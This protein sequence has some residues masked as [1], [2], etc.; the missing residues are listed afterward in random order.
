MTDDPSSEPAVRA[1]RQAHAL[2]NELPS[3]G[4]RARILQAAAS[5]GSTPPRRA[6]FAFGGG[7]FLPRWFRGPSFAGAAALGFVVV[8]AIS[9]ALYVDQSQKTYEPGAKGIEIAQNSSGIAATPAAP[10]MPSRTMSSDRGNLVAEAGARGAAALSGSEKERLAVPDHASDLPSF[11]SKPR[12]DAASGAAGSPAN[13]ALALQEAQSAS[14]AVAAPAK[15][16]RIASVPDLSRNS[17]GLSTART[18]AQSAAPAVA[19]QGV[20]SEELQ[21]KAGSPVYRS[22]AKSWLE[23]IEAL[24]KAC[25]DDQADAELKLFHETYPQVPVPEDLRGP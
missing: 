1:L 7:S 4:A 22:S 25:R 21:T 5:V 14:G 20:A 8:L 13:R 2:L 6:R 10:Q 3:S 16:A 12:Q 11:A 23:R 19:T 15:E 24:R 17:V 9:L 18:C